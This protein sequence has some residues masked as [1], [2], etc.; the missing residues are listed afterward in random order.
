[1]ITL[2]IKKIKASKYESTQF[3]I[4]FWFFS[5]KNEVEKEVYTLIKYKLYLMDGFKANI[6]IENNILLLKNFVINVKKNYIFIE[7][8]KLIIA[9]NTR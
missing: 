6:L 4:F 2:I 3:A 7:S 9:I 5:G 8:C 1:M